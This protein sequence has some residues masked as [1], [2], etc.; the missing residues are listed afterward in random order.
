MKNKRIKICI[1]IIL[2]TAILMCGVLS[3]CDLPVATNPGHYVLSSAFT[4]FYEIPG[5]TEDEIT[6]I[7]MLK[8]SREFFVYAMIPST[9]AFYNTAFTEGTEE[10]RGFTA[11]FCQYMTD[12]FDIEFK[13]ALYEWSDLVA[14][15]ESGEIDFTGDLTPS[16][17]RRLTYFMTDAIAARSIKTYRY[18]YSPPLA[19]IAKERPLKLAFLNGA[20]T[21]DKITPHLHYDYEIVYLDDLDVIYGMLTSGAI[22]A[23]YGDG[24]AESIFD[25]YGYI[26][27]IDFFPLVYSPVSLTTQ[28]RELEAIISVVQ[29]ALDAGEMR[30]L[31]DL[32]NR[33]YNEYR[34]YRL[35][36]EFTEEERAYLHENKTIP[37]AAEFDVYPKSFYNMNDKA[38][39]GIVIDALKEVEILTGFEFV[40][41]NGPGTDFSDL[42]IMME[43]K[44]ALFITELVRTPERE[45]H[46]I[47]P[48]IVF[49]TDQSALISKVDFHNINVNEILAVRVGVQRDGAHR[50]LFLSWFPDHRAIS[51]YGSTDEAILALE[52]DEIDMF[53]ES[54]STLLHLTNYQELV[55]YKANFV[56]DNYFD[57]T[58]GFRNDEAILCSIIDKTLEQVD[59]ETISGQ[60]LRRT[61]D[62]RSVVAEARTPWIVGA[63]VLLMFVF[64]LYIV[65]L[66]KNR[67]VDQLAMQTKIREQALDAENNM[68]DTLNRMKTKFFQNM[69]HNL[70]TPLTVISTDIENAMDYLDPAF[71]FEMDKEDMLE[72]LLHAQDEIMRMARIVDGALQYATLSKE[73]EETGPLDIADLLNKGAASYRAILEQHGNRLTLNIP[74]SVSHVSGNED[75]LLQVLSN[76]MA[77]ANRFTRNG[78]I[79]INVAEKEGFVSVTIR[80]TGSGIKPELLPHIFERGVTDGGT[81][82]GLPIC[83]SAIES[84]GGEILVYSALGQGTSV[85]FTLPVIKSE[86]SKEEKPKEKKPK[87]E[88]KSN[89]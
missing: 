51:E 31:N 85:T 70:K 39:Q 14:G 56:F 38:F 3:G 53:M 47:W 83:K 69:S 45:K 6:A 29:K 59:I 67:Q 84:M 10:I 42:L 75:T 50:D 62:Y 79:R 2:I 54:L 23:F 52:N 46:Y 16:D 55:G 21:N 66:F 80:D 7:E 77:N 87:E 78:E 13:P 58:L 30:Y 22:D 88:D 74:V 82:L 65:M 11:L 43:D 68:L 28:N 72:S 89:E 36:L 1:I 86:E 19:E 25:D 5:V 18:S 33:G 8:E 34:R 27:A 9:E 41:A 57:S 35:F 71:D 63:Y 73:Q 12:L 40:I 60:W 49:M 20:I 37:F 26:E 81:G 48:D 76:L 32:Y 24:T 64:V 4:S 15:L 17:E 44:K 61:F